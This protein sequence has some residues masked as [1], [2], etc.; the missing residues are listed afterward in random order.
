MESKKTKPRTVLDNQSGQDAGGI[1]YGRIAAI[2]LPLLLAGAAL[3]AWFPYATGYGPER[4]PIAYWLY[5]FWKDPDWQHGA[6]VLPIIGAILWFRRG[7]LL[8]GLKGP[9]HWTGLLVVLLGL[10]C[11]VAGYR[12]NIYYLGFASFQILAGGL[13]IWMLGY[14]AFR[15]LFFLWAFLVFAW[16]LFFLENRLGFPLRLLMADVCSSILNVAGVENVRSGTAIYSVANP[17]LGLV[18]G[19]RFAMGVADPCSGLRSLFALL[20]TGALYGYWKFGQTWRAATLFLCAIPLALAGNV[21]RILLL[22]GGIRWLGGEVAIG[23]EEDPTLFHTGA[24][25][26]VFAFALVGLN[27]ISRLLERL[28][29]GGGTPTARPVSNKGAASGENSGAHPSLASC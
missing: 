18:Q 5:N 9:G 28:N 27:L 24:G 4:E 17:E 3:F 25:L 7:T 6:L 23:T 8:A 14:G 26:V 12:G 1:G 20:M 16:P 21:I 22:L 11:Y 10:L 2:A 19:E 13:L 29:R 15:R